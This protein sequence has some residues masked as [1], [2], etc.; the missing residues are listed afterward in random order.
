MGIDTSEVTDELREFKSSLRQR[1]GDGQASERNQKM[2]AEA[3]ST[4]D[5]LDIDG[6]SS[7]MKLDKLTDAFHDA[8]SK[9]KKELAMKHGMDLKDL[10]SMMRRTD[11]LGLENIDMEGF[12]SK[13]QQEAVFAGL[14]RS[15][16]HDIEK[17]VAAEEE[18]QLKLTGTVNVT[19]VIQGEG[20]FNDVTGA[21]T[22]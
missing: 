5:D 10:E 8:D 7:I 3:L 2:L 9:G 16:G 22:R 20:T 12:S 13:Q 17:E 19:G 18:R 6:D 1:A 4:V 14:E 15:M 21:T 11:F